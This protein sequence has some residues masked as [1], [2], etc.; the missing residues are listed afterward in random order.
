MSRTA[1]ILLVA[2]LAASIAGSYF[3]LSQ[4]PDENIHVFE[5][6]R[7]GAP[8]GNDVVKTAEAPPIEEEVALAFA[9]FGTVSVVPDMML[10][11]TGTNV[12]SPEF[13]EAPNV[14]DTLLLVSAKGND[15]VEVWKYPFLGTELPPLRLAPTP[16][17]LDVD[18]DRDML[19]VGDSQERIIRVYSLPD[20]AFVRTIGKGEIGSGETN[21]DILDRGGKKWVFVS[22]SH[23]V[24]A[25]DLDTGELLSSFEPQVESIEEI[26][27]DSF[28]QTIY[29]PEEEGI[30]SDVIRNGG[31][32]AHTPSGSPLPSDGKNIFGNT[33]VFSG[34]AEGVTLYTCPSDGSR[35]D[36]NGLIIVADQAGA[37]TGFKFFDRRT[38]AY[39][40]TL[41]LRGVT[42]TDGIASTQKPLPLYPTGLF[43]ATNSD[44]SVALVS[45]E[46]ILAATKLSCGG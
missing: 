36:G 28:S 23:A 25:F 44:A 14:E 42:G 5:R 8:A 15:L 13:W 20:Q 22:E 2:I 10:D 33:G 3:F 45:W 39:L 1:I 41:R 30:T 40:G 26:L 12:D 18:Q 34:D 19:I 11:G 16:N 46:K 37:A 31:I 9:P 24:K 21:I 35:D 17:G 7:M 6:E 27:A 38:W 4:K 32:V 29:V 43:A